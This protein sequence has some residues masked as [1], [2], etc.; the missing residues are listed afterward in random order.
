MRK[1]S[2]RFEAGSVEEKRSSMAHYVT[3]FYEILGLN[4]QQWHRDQEVELSDK[5]RF[6]LFGFTSMKVPAPEAL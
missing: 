5:M 1:I 6:S 2:I 4:P 3:W